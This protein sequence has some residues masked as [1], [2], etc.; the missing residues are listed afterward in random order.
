MNHAVTAHLS[1]SAQV[2]DLH[3]L[4]HYYSCRELHWVAET[5]NHIQ[6]EKS[7]LLAQ[8]P[9]SLDLKELDSAMEK[10]LLGSRNS[11]QTSRSELYHGNHLT[12]KQEHKDQDGYSSCMKMAQ[13]QSVTFSHFTVA[14]V[15]FHAVEI[16]YSISNLAKL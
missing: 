15:L 5:A 1:N 2:Y 10:D 3:G 11:L 14:V 9:E 16:R 6:C 8:R 4:L 7:H 13:K 12:W